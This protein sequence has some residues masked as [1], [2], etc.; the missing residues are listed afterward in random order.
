MNNWKAGDRALCVDGSVNPDIPDGEHPVEG[1]IYIVTGIRDYQ[2]PSGNIGLYIAGLFGGIN[3]WLEEAPFNSKRFRKIVPA[4]DR[5]AI[6]QEQE[7][8][9]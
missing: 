5:V 7:A 6:E 4:C 1:N 8:T 3:A 2:L 9:P